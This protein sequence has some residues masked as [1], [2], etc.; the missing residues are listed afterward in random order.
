MLTAATRTRPGSRR[1]LLGLPLALV[2]MTASAQQEPLAVRSLVGTCAQCHGT[3]G[4]APADS[5]L[6]S[7][8]GQPAELLLSKLTAFKDRSV[9]TTVMTQI[10]RGYSDAQ[11]RALAAYFAA[12]PR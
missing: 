12:R 7:L 4:R 2:A 5:L 11:L 10:A 1:F 8:A 6:P 3:D 9:S